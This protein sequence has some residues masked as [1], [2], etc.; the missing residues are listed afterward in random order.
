MDIHLRIP[1]NAEEH[2]A[3]KALAS[4]LG[5]PVEEWARRVL[6]KAKAE[7]SHTVESK[8]KAIAKASNHDFP[9][10]DIEEMLADIEAGRRLP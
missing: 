2:E 8:L 6:L 9:S 1:L 3:L 4:R 7:Q 10:A 5:E